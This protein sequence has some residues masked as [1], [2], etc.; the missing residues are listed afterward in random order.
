[1]PYYLHPGWIPAGA[2]TMERKQKLTPGWTRKYRAIYRP[3]GTLRDVHCAGWLFATI[4]CA[5]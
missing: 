3:T 5:K 1:M 2:T 4:G